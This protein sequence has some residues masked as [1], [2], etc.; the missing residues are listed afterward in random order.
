MLGSYN[1][2]VIFICHLQTIYGSISLRLS[3]SV[4]CRRG[5]YFEQGCYISALEHVWMLI[6][7][8]YVLLAGKN[9]VNKY[10]HTWVSK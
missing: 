10:S 3:D 2:A 4:K 1:S 7:S 5:Y 6:L 9:A 8:S